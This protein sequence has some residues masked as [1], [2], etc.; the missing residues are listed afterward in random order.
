MA[1]R[2]DDAPHNRQD[3]IERIQSRLPAL[4]G[5]RER[6]LLPDRI[7][8]LEV[9]LHLS[10][11][12][13]FP[14]PIVDLPEAGLGDGLEPVGSGENARRFTSA[15]ERARV[16]G[17]SFS[18][19]SLSARL[20]ACRRPSSDK[21]TSEEPAN[22]SSCV[23]WVAP[24]RTRKIRV[25]MAMDSLQRRDARSRRTDARPVKA[26]SGGG[27][28]TAWTRSQRSSGATGCART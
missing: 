23:S 2:L 28:L 8:G 20:A 24:C 6:I 3:A 25:G 19:F 18:F 17:S 11:P 7:F 26:A 16:D 21:V 12:Q 27:T 14:T 9:A 22:R 4:R 1:M 10:A 5:D 13:T 15:G